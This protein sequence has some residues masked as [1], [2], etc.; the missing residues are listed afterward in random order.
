MHGRI[1]LDELKIKDGRVFAPDRPGLGLEL[2]R[3]SL[4]EFRVA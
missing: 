4:A 3:E 1:Y 2:N